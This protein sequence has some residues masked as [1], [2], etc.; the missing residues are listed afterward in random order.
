[1]FRSEGKILLTLFGDYIF[2][3]MESQD[4]AGLKKVNFGPSVYSPQGGREGRPLGTTAIS[5]LKISK[6]DPDM[7]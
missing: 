1:M 5:H 2:H 7:A 4:G 6:E 3:L